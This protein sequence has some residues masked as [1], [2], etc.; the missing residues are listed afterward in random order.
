MP[1]AVSMRKVCDAARRCA[2]MAPGSAIL[3]W[4]SGMVAQVVAAV[5]ATEAFRIPA[6]RARAAS[7]SLRGSAETLVFVAR[8]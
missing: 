7:M 5:A 1:E 4:G 8:H 2:M 6:S 3:S